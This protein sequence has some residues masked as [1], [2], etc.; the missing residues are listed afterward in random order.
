[1]IQNKKFFRA[2]AYFFCYNLAGGDFMTI[3]DL[4]I[5]G[6]KYA[7]IKDVTIFEKIH[8]HGI[9]NLTL[10]VDEKFAEKENL[11]YLCTSNLKD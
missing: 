3:S 7:A 5:E 11:P 6:I 8:S 4:K 2:K 10:L 1:M 9:C